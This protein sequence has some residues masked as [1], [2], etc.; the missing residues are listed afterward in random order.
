MTVGIRLR[1]STSGLRLTPPPFV[2]YQ[3]VRKAAKVYLF[4]V[5]QNSDFQ[6]EKRGRCRLLSCA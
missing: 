6:S 4:G 2:D 1:I 3:A 5:S